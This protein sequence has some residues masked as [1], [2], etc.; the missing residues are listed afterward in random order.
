[1]GI[2]KYYIFCCELYIIKYNLERFFCESIEIDV[3]NI[4]F[5]LY[6]YEGV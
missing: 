2:L 6:F 4:L 1:M 3:F 5:I